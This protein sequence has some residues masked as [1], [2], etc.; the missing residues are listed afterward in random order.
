[1][2]RRQLLLAVMGAAAAWPGMVLS[3]PG[4]PTPVIGYLGLTSPQALASRLA[5]FRQGIGELGYVEDRTLAFEYRWAEGRYDRLAAL[6]AD[7]VDRKVAVIATSGPPAA[8]AAKGATS[9]IPIVFVLGSDPVRDGLVASLARPGG[10][11]TGITLLAVDVS[12]KRLDLLAEL[13]PDAKSIALL[14][15]PDNAAEERV[16]A[17]VGRA[18]LAKGYRLHVFEARTEQEID[19]AF[20]A[21]GQLRTAALFVSPDSF[22]TSRREQIASLAIR[23][24][25]PAIYAFR[26]FA[27]SGGLISYAPNIEAVYREAGRYAGRIL[28]GEDPAAL[29][30]QQPT[31]FELVIN[32]KTARSMGVEIPPSLL[33]R[34]DEVIE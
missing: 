10:N 34:A 16:V 29:P 8:R 9:T 1:M 21:L 22:F 32:L 24:T 19:A 25:Q 31:T 26:E 15:N 6:A 4:T 20:A 17:E 12:L 14:A 18:A 33:A 2:R 30:V 11:V 27:E 5:A 23:H 13:M 3:Q 28:K 7:L